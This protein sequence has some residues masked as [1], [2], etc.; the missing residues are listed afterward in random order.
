MDCV[1]AENAAVVHERVLEVVG[2]LEYGWAQLL[3]AQ[4][5]HHSKP[6]A[7]VSAL[8]ARK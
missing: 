5:I 2:R 6:M 4:S 8:V 1:V 7:Q 3:C